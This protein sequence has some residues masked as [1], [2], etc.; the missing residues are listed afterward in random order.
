[1]SRAS[2]WILIEVSL[3]QHKEVAVALTPPLSGLGFVSTELAP[4]EEKRKV[5]ELIIHVT[6]DLEAYCF[7]SFLSIT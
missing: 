3:P 4:K 1:M 5:P 7:A 6:Y 2:H